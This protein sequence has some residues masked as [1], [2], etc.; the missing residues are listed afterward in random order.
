MLDVPSLAAADVLFPKN[1]ETLETDGLGR[2]KYY[3]ERMMGTILALIVP[4]SLVI[5]LLPQVYR[6]RSWQAAKI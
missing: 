6:L 4:I 2:V 1:V 3:F 5:F